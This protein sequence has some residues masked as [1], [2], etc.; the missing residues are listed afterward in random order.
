VVLEVGVDVRV[1]VVVR[2]GIGRDAR[3]VERRVR[4]EA[5]L[6]LA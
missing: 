5:D 3:G 2:P 1:D 4:G 6:G